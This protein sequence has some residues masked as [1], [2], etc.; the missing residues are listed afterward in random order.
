MKL[1]EHTEY[2]T[3]LFIE[4][5]KIIKWYGLDSVEFASWLVSIVL[6]GIS[7]VISIKYAT[8]SFTF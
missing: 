1:G 5:N 3:S 7:L 8:I 4:K 2:D 6:M